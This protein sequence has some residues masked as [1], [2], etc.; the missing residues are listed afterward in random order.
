MNQTYNR[1]R[2]LAEIEREIERQIRE[3]PQLELDL[4]APWQ[5]QPRAVAPTV[6]NLALPAFL[7]IQAE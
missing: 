4:V 5:Y 7:A 3:A 1:L 2:R 6:D